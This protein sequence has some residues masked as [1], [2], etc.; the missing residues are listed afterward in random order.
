MWIC[1]SKAGETSI[2]VFKVIAHKNDPLTKCIFQNIGLDHGTEL[3]EEF[4][5]EGVRLGTNRL[6]DQGICCSPERSCRK[7]PDLLNCIYVSK[8]CLGHLDG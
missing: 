8:P 7:T 2:L 5:S 4:F 1:D 6:G 3:C